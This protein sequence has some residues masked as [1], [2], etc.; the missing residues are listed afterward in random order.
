MTVES[1]FS[2]NIFLDLKQQIVENI[3]YSKS[4]FEMSK[5]KKSKKSTAKNSA[6]AQQRKKQK[7]KLRLIKTKSKLEHRYVERPPMAEIDAPP[8]FRAVSGSQ[9]IME[10]SKSVVNFDDSENIEDMNKILQF[11]SLLWNYGISVESGDINEK[12]TKEIVTMIQQIWKVEEDSARKLLDKFV[13]KRNEMFP[14]EVQIQGSP[15]MYMRK[16]ISHLIAPFDYKKIE[17]SGEVFPPDDKDKA[18]TDK[19]ETIDSYI[20]DEKDYS[21]WEDEYFSM[22][23]ACKESFTRWLQKKGGTGK[24]AQ[25][26]PFLSEIFM[27][28][29]YRYMHDD[30]IVL[31]SVRS[32]Y[33]EEFFFDYVLRKVMMEPHEHVEWPPALKLFYTFLLEKEYLDNPAVFIEVIDDLE[34][35]F[36]DVL[37]KRFS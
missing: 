17:L 36:I 25:E 2:C 37:R 32:I 14:P 4:G 18:F 10:Y 30:I 31:K 11:T 13:E 26:F 3:E 24:N 21:D 16:E 15:M 12:I 20:Q 8:G 19:L 34:P 23:E 33:F 28:F 35:K 22:E 7:R 5:K 27:N 1:M 6:K 29:V 9:A